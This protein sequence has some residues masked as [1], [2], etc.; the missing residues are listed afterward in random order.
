MAHAQDIDLHDNYISFHRGWRHVTTCAIHTSQPE[1][2]WTDAAGTRTCGTP[3]ED[4]RYP[5]RGRAVW[6]R[7]HAVPRTRTCGLG[8]RTCGTPHEDV[9]F[10]HED[11]RY[12]ARGR[13]VWAR[14]HAVPRTRTCAWG[15]RTCGTP[16]E[17]V[18]SG[19]EDVWYP[20]RGRA[21]GARTGAWAPRSQRGPRSVRGRL[22]VKRWPCAWLQARARAHR[23]IAPRAQ[24][25]TRPARG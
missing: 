13:A 7:G 16:Q 10:G 9:R 1:P 21:L 3:H 17:D 15:T 20:A 25:W 18:R 12:P 11:M 24:R 23:G 6:A 4:M 8:T 2:P 19:H 22:D 5:A 14:G